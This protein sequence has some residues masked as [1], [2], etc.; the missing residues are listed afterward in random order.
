MTETSAGHRVSAPTALRPEGRAGAMSRTLEA[1]R[2]VL[3]A[4]GGKWGAAKQLIKARPV[5]WR[6]RTRCRV[7]AAADASCGPRSSIRTRYG[8]PCHEGAHEEMLRRRGHGRREIKRRHRWH[9]RHSSSRCSYSNSCTAGPIPGCAPGRGGGNARR[10]RT[11]SRRAGT[12]PGRDAPRSRRCVRVVA[13]GRAPPPAR[14]TR[15]DQTIPTG[16]RGAHAMRACSGA[17]TERE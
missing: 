8:S 12:S 14:R 16:H 4:V 6:R 13:H 7:H 2:G 1:Y 17:A 3:G 11:N 15:P 10:A 5:G 9:T